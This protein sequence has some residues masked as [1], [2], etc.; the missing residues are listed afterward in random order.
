LVTKEPWPGDAL[1]VEF[2]A[3]AMS[4]LDGAH[5]QTFFYPRATSEECGR[6]G[7]EVPEFTV[8]TSCYGKYHWSRINLQV[9]CPKWSRHMARM[10][11]DGDFCG[12]FNR[13]YHIKSERIGQ[14]FRLWVDGVPVCERE[15]ETAPPAQV[16]PVLGADISHVRFRNLTIC[17]P[18]DAYVR[19]HRHPLSGVFRPYSMERDLLAKYP[20]KEV[21]TASIKLGTRN[22]ERGIREWGGE[23]NDVS[24]VPA[25]TGRRAC[26]RTDLNAKEGRGEYFCFRVDDL[27]WNR[28]N[29]VYLDI[30]CFDRGRGA[31][32]AIYNTW[33]YRETP[34][35]DLPMCDT[36]KWITQTTHLREVCF[37]EPDRRHSHLLLT[38]LRAAGQD[39]H[40]SGLRLRELVR[41]PEAYEELLGI[42][43]SEA[44][45]HHGTWPEPHYR[46][47]MYRVLK[48]NL[49]RHAEADMVLR[50][51][52]EQ[53]SGSE[54]LDSH[55]YMQAKLL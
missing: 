37:R 53:H 24:T 49:K 28:F 25:R 18:D 34:G 40:I 33:Y 54:C 22:I 3:L 44:R 14:I 30:D 46:Y 51:L 9:F 12:V 2:D 36:G 47:A 6:D 43:R 1:V 52:I 38:P 50:E 10:R 5:I 17:R 20:A 55:H 13:W 26:R 31:I 19:E 15:A 45:R 48:H 42:F 29:E 16:W 39:L 4:G 21:R 8:E 41:P 23:E 35:E 11:P 7:V 32:S 27:G